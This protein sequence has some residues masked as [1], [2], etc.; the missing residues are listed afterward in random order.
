MAAAIEQQGAFRPNGAAR[1]LDCSRDTV[2]RLCQSG[3]LRSFT[4]GSARFISAKEL[5]RFVAE[6]EET[7]A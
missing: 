7:N 6:R 2:D 1:W 4:V 3:A 5:E